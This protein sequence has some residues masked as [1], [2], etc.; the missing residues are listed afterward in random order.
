MKRYEAG[1]KDSL[2]GAAPATTIVAGGGW[3]TTPP[4]AGKETLSVAR[5]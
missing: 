4:W 3:R 5:V 2:R 1:A